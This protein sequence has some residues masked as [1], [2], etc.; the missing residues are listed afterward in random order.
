MWFFFLAQS[1]YSNHNDTPAIHSAA[2]CNYVFL[3]CQLCYLNPSKLQLMPG[4]LMWSC[5]EGDEEKRWLV[6]HLALG[7][8]LWWT[9]QLWI[10]R[11]I[12]TPKSPRLAFTERYSLSLPVLFPCFCFH[13][14]VRTIPVVCLSLRKTYARYCWIGELSIERETKIAV[15]GCDVCP[16]SV[17]R[18][19]LEFTPFGICWEWQSPN[20]ISLS[21]IMSNLYHHHQYLQS[22]SGRRHRGR[23]P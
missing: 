18:E 8:G 16:V 4:F 20:W 23:L 13:D 7:F 19:W 9:S 14:I 15:E 11:Y 21:E 3:Y 12:W 22:C 17:Q 5:T 6:W 1:L 10:T 2:Y